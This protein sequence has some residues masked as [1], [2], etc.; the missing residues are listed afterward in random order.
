MP[1]MKLGQ[2]VSSKLHIYDLQGSLQLKSMFQF[3]CTKAKC[4]ACVL[5]FL[6]K[7]AGVSFKNTYIT[8][9][10]VPLHHPIV[11]CFVVEK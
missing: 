2:D 10:L 3:S 9:K 11:T 4:I 8:H 6:H 1:C 7:G 5:S